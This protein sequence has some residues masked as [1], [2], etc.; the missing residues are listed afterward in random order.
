[1]ENYLSQEFLYMLSIPI[2]GTAIIGEM[3]YSHY[4]KRKLYTVGDTATNVYMATLNFLLDLLMKGIAFGVLYFFYHYRIFDFAPEFGI[5]YWIMV[6]LLQDFAYYVHHYV[7]H[8]SRFFW[9]VH[10]THHNSEH[11]NISTGF[12]SPVFQPLYRYIFFLPLALFGFHPLHIIGVYAILQIYGTLIHTESVKKM[13][14]LEWILVTPSHH[15]VHHA[16]N[17]KYLDK[18]MGMFLIIWDRIFGT[19]Q[20]EEDDYEPIKYGLTS[21][22]EDKGPVNIVFHEWKSIWED[23]KRPDINWKQRLKY[24]FYPPGWS[25][26]GSRKTSRQIQQEIKEKTV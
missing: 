25:H 20:K 3:V 10:V 11:F 12:R 26:D 1:M 16:S 8:Y 15:R 7:D 17:G 13:G 24:I 21:T 19:F 23:V 9:A 18:N 14:V 6:F 4:I 5:T 22:I 2:H